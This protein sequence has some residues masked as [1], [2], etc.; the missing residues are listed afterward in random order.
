MSPPCASLLLLRQY[1]S[2]SSFDSFS[3]CT[4]AS[5]SLVAYLKLL[6][7]KT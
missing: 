3:T 2:C 6:S 1:L 4:Y 5:A 7:P